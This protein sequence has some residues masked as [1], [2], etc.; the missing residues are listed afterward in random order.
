MDETANPLREGLRASACRAPCAMV[1]FG[2]S[3]DLTKR[4]LVPA[5]Y[6]LARE[7][8]CRRRFAVVGMA[9]RE[10]PDDEFRANMKEAST[11]SRAAA[12]S[13]RRCGTLRPGISYVNGTFD[14]P[15]TYGGSR[16][17]SKASTRS[18]ARAATASS[19][20][21]TPPSEYRD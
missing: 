7:R 4:K 3:G 21:S 13:T 12:P 9:R 5:L 14:D 8:C 18:A 15:A 6:T 19:T 10:D 2:A 20:S 16:G 1:I 11:S 17:T